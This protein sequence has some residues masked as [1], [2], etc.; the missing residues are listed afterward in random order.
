MVGAAAGTL[1]CDHCC[2]FGA[3]GPGYADALAARRGGVPVC[4]AEGGAEDAGR[5]G[6]AGEGALAA[7]G[8]AAVEGGFAALCG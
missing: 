3:G 4:V 2:D 8:V 6:V 5:E 7:G 1:V